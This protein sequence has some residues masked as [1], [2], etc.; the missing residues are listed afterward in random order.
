MVALAE[1]C[2]LLG[3]GAVHEG[4]T[5]EGALEAAA[6]F[7]GGKLE[8]G[9]GRHGRVVGPAGDPRIR[10]GGITGWAADPAIGPAVPLVVEETEHGIAGAKG[11]R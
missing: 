7:R 3:T 4:G 2:I 9:V 5:I 11:K 10:W 8:A 1:P 6:A